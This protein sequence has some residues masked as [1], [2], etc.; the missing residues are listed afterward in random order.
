VVKSYGIEVAFS[1]MSF[2]WN[3][4]KGTDYSKVIGGKQGQTDIKMV[5]S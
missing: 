1:G 2:L 4:I 3:F 5:M